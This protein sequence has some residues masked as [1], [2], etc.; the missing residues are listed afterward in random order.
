MS[1][2]SKK[3]ALNPQ[4]TRKFHTNLPKI[5]HQ[6]LSMSTSR[7]IWG[8]N[9]FFNISQSLVTCFY[10]SCL[11]FSYATSC[12]HFLVLTSSERENLLHRPFLIS[13]KIARNV[14]WMHGKWSNGKYGRNFV[15]FM[16]RNFLNRK[17]III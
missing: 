17:N 8:D 6:T 3:C 16:R 15:R 10:T 13:C 7:A 11:S 4:L 2:S 12:I 9:K 1:N 14:D 5:S